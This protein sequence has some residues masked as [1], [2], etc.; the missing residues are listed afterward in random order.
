MA[1]IGAYLRRE[2]ELRGISL[3]EVAGATKISIRL[4]E[5]LES[6]DHSALPPPVFVKGF[7]RA[8][9]QHIGLDPEDAV[10]RYEDYLRQQE[11]ESGGKAEGDVEERGPK[12]LLKRGL[13]AATILIIL[14]LV[15]PFK[16]DEGRPP[17]GQKPSF[18]GHT[19]H[20]K[21]SEPT[22]IRVVIDGKDIKERLLRPGDEVEWRAE[23]GFFVVIGNAG[24]VEVSLDGRSL[25]VLGESG[26]VLRMSL[27]REAE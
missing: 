15:V 17:L 10:L 16:G 26:Q 21:A 18:Q 24:G 1:T 23:R 11:G 4:L 13:V 3:E 22:W 20:F 19:L 9:A 7:I 2:R 8:Y 12:W 27:P 25:G 14:Y 5:A 6:D